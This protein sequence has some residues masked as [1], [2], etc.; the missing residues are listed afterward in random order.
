MAFSTFTALCSCHLCVVSE[1]FHHTQ[2][3]L[4]EDASLMSI[5]LP[6]VWWKCSETTQRWQLHKAVNVL[7][8]IAL[9]TFKQWILRQ[10]ERE[11]GRER[12]FKV[13]IPTTQQR[14]EQSHWC[15]WK[16]KCVRLGAAPQVISSTP[17]AWVLLHILL[18]GPTSPVIYLFPYKNQLVSRSSISS[19]PLKTSWT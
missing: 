6:W 12:R 10:R 8:A 5:G 16:G 19:P 14:G 9:C 2:G 1:H 7:N 18:L 13:P 17:L 11:G 15:S 3:R 4:I